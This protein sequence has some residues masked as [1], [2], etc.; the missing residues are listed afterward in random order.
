MDS[1]S[2]KDSSKS[3]ILK[4]LKNTKYCGNLKFMKSEYMKK[5]Y[6]K[7]LLASE[8][9]ILYHKNLIKH[10]NNIYTKYYYSKLLTQH[11][12]LIKKS[13][14]KTEELLGY[15]CK[16]TKKNTIN[17]LKHDLLILHTFEYQTYREALNILSEIKIFYKN[18]HKYDIEDQIDILN[19]KTNLAGIEYLKTKLNNN[20][21]RNESNQVED[22]I[23]KYKITHDDNLLND[24]I[25]IEK[26]TNIEEFTNITY[27]SY[28]KNTILILILFIGIVYFNVNR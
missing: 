26:K 18:I 6:S 12:E 22:I 14:N 9:N 21:M 24:I 2:E 11:A 5:S 17:N 23:V 8:N 10:T 16:N 4:E 28:N 25:E 13:I 20:N 1:I 15:L 3:L 19:Y 27:N 7:L